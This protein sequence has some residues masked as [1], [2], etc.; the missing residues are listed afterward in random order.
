MAKETKTTSPKADSVENA[1]AKAAPQAKEATKEQPRKMGVVKSTLGVLLAACIVTFI[2]LFLPFTGQGGPA[3]TVRTAWEAVETKDLETFQKVVSTDAFVK[4]L[5]EQVIAYEEINAEGVT[6]SNFRQLMNQGMIGAFR[7]DLA[8]TYG[9]QL[10][11]LV[12]TGN[13]DQ[14]KDGLLWR[15]WQQTGEKPEY[16]KDYEVLDQNDTNALLTLN[17][18]RPDLGGTVLSLNLLLEYNTQTEGWQITGVPNLANF[19]F[20]ISTRQKEQLA[21]LNAPI[22]KRLNE[23]VNILDVQKASGVGEN[24]NG[25]LWRVAYRNTSSRNIASFDATLTIKNA[26]G[27]YL[28]ELPISDEDGLASGQTAE[29]AWPMPLNVNNSADAEILSASPRTLQAEVS[30]TKVVFKN[31]DRL[32]MFTEL[33]EPFTPTNGAA[34]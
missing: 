32:T 30:V 15:L 10:S 12:K 23:T 1:Q 6:A 11:E 22:Q 28:G 13:L 25:V 17:F 9:Q 27:K 14:R 19:L 26:D 31:G 20:T 16:F 3:K 34:E 24:T 33:P 4:S 21:E 29:R 7:N 5:I 8:A 2:W 18:E